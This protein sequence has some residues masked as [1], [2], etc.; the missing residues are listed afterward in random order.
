M[1]GHRNIKVYYWFNAIEFCEI[2]TMII[3][4]RTTQ[5]VECVHVWCFKIAETKD[6]ILKY[7]HYCCHAVIRRTYV[8]I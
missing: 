5:F 2:V 6:K 8:C 3:T 1:H 4:F 7:A